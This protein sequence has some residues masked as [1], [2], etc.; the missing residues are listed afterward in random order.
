MTTTDKKAE[1]PKAEAK[2]PDTAV[3]RILKAGDGKV[4]KG[5]HD[6]NGEHYYAKGE[7]VLLPIAIATAL[8]NRGFVEIQ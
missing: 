5:Q 7:E 3:V 1:A 6:L 8:E 4:S 2:A